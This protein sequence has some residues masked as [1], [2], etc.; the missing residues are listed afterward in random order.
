M[1]VPAALYEQLGLEVPPFFGRN[2]IVRWGVAD[3]DAWVME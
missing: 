1:G 2:P 3:G